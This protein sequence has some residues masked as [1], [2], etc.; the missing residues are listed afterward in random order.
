MTTRGATDLS[1]ILCVDK[2]AG[3]TSHDVVAGV[4]RIT[5]ERR[6]GHAGTL[7]PMATGVLVVLVGP[8]TRLAP[9]LTSE[10]KLYSARVVFGSATDTDDAEGQVITTLPVPQEVADNGFATGKVES[11][12]GTFEQT[13]PAYSAI[14]LA[15]KKAYDLARAGK[16]VNIAPRTVSILDARLDGIVEGPPVVWNLTVRV[17]KGFYVR[18]LARDLGVSLG[19]AAHLVGL[20]RLASGKLTTS[21]ARTL[22]ILEDADDVGEKFIPAR[23]VL[24]I[25]AMSVSD[26]IAEKVSSGMQLP[27]LLV[28]DDQAGPFAVV[29]RGR[30]IAIYA[31]SEHSLVPEAVFPG[32]IT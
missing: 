12:V 7:D 22:D 21:N 3:M 20:R 23:E 29:A 9:Y 26:A 10:D 1:G 27:S 11:L 13:P 18:S 8:A 24:E 31:R 16:E 6:V 30:V 17:S 2:P 14:K 32:G 15:G 19:T 25:D 4:R 28:D 5:G